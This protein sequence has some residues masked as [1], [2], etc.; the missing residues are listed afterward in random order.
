MQ[1][2]ICIFNNVHSNLS[3]T[4]FETYFRTYVRDS[5]SI[6]RELLLKLKPNLIII[7]THVYGD[8]CAFRLN[9]E[10]RRISA[11]I[12]VIIVSDEYDEIQAVKFFEINAD[13]Y[14]LLP[15]RNREF[16]SRVNAHI[17]KSNNNSSKINKVSLGTLDVYPYQYKVTLEGQEVILSNKEFSTLML[18][19]NNQSKVLSRTAILN[20]LESNP[21]SDRNRQVDVYISTLRKRLN[22]SYIENRKQSSEFY[23]KTIQGRGYIF[24]SYST[25]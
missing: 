23:I 21:K 3:F 18:L 9:L 5:Y 10:V 12:P 17:R 22:L 7:C 2:S 8:E 11:D 13:D 20:Y 6:S 1:N 25:N 15:L 4:F 16:I 19:I 24:D 14:V